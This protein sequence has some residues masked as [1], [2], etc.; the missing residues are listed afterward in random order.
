M[1]RLLRWSIVIAAVVLLAGASASLLGCG[2]SDPYSGTWKA[3]PGAHN[4]FTSTPGGGSLTL[5]IKK[6]N[7]GW[8]S[9]ALQPTPGVSPNY[10]AEID[11]ELQSDN[12]VSTFKRSGDRLVFTL[13]RGAQPITLTRQ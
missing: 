8:W 7:P 10:A 3:T 6:A 2:S 9:V 4:G 1:S 5:I 11:G 13:D 12:G